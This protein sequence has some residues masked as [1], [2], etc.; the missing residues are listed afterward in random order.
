MLFYVCAQHC[1]Q[2]ISPKHHVKKS[3]SK[4]KHFQ[5][6]FLYKKQNKKKKKSLKTIN[7][8]MNLINIHVCVK[9]DNHMNWPPG[10]AF[11][12]ECQKT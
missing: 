6:I 9:D 5:R 7:L 3:Q 8:V 10:I 11:N 2:S 4:Y 12:V 1:P